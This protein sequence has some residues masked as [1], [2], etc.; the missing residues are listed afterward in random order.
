MT[1]G[2]D[3]NFLVAEE[4]AEHPEHAGAWRRIGELR[5][6]GG[7]FVL[8]EFVHVV[9]DARR[10]THP[11]TMSE[12]LEKARLWWEAEEVEQA[13][14]TDDAVKWFLNAMARHRLGRKRVLDTMLASIYRSAGITSLLTLNGEDFAVFGELS[15]L[16]AAVSPVS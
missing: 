3:T 5:N 8:A 16:G 7:R 1:H 11:L 10:F 9:T 4:V 14:P 12:A 6:A 2:F 15:C 13:A